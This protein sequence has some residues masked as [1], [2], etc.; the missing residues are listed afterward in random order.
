MV[1]D[2][3]NS[4]DKHTPGKFISKPIHSFDIATSYEEKEVVEYLMED[5]NKGEFHPASEVQLFG[6][7]YFHFPIKL[8]GRLAGESENSVVEKIEVR[9]TIFGLD[10]NI[11]YSLD[12]SRYAKR[13]S[14]KGEYFI[15]WGTVVK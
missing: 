7:R 8:E 15:T 1:N 5:F 10:L 12:N 3:R 14:W 6:H 9:E 13:F 11:T 4:F 2:V